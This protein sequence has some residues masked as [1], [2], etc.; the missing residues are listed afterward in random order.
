MRALLSSLLC[1]LCCTLS[2]DEPMLDKV[3]VFPA[4]MNEVTLYRIPGIVVTTKGIVLAYS[5]ARTNTRKDW[6]EIEVHI[7]RSTDGGKTWD[8]A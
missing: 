3:D 4:G 2:A 5:E 7:R 6:G 8:A 1:L